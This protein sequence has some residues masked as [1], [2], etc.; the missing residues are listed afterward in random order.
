MLKIIAGWGVNSGVVRSKTDDGCF[1]PDNVKV[2]KR[3]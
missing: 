2:V 1:T 3:T